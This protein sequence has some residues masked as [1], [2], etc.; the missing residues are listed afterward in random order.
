MKILM[1]ILKLSVC[2]NFKDKEGINK[3]AV[4]KSF[5]AA[6]LVTVQ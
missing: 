4:G 2:V 1:V 5:K 3:L 6:Y